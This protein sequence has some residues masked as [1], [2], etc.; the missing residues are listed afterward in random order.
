DSGSGLITLSD[1]TSILGALTLTGVI[2]DSDGNLVLDD[3]VDLGSASTGVRV[4]TT[5]SLSDIDGNLVLDDTVDIGSA[6][7][8]IRITPSGV[9]TD[10][11]GA[12][13]DVDDTLNANALTSDT[14]V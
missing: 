2:S 10:I 14:G 13:V 5:G 8:G 7:T 11:D 3:I 6:T 4:A 12:I 1:S 9:I